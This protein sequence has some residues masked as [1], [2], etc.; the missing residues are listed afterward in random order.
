MSPFLVLEARIHQLQ[1][2]DFLLDVQ[3]AKVQFVKAPSLEK[4]T[5]SVKGSKSIP[6][7]VNAIHKSRQMVH[8]GTHPSRWMKKITE[9]KNNKLKIQQDL[10]QKIQ[11]IQK[12]PTAPS[13]S[14]NGKRSL[15]Q[16]GTSHKTITSTG[17]KKASLNNKSKGQLSLADGI[18]AAVS[19]THTSTVTT[20]A[21]GIAAQ[22]HKASKGKHKHSKKHVSTEEHVSGAEGRAKELLEAE[23][24]QGR[25]SQQAQQWASSSNTQQLQE[26]SEGNVNGDIHLKIRSYLE[27]CVF[28][29]ETER[30]HHFLLSQHRVRRYR[31]HLKTDV[32]N[33][34]MRVWAKKVSLPLDI[35]SFS[36]YSVNIT[37]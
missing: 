30:A 3:H 20:S 6:H 29:G 27:A 17:K 35:L 8:K 7:E 31:K 32:Y 25:H 21:A 33:I 1:S 12:N 15:M 24:L 22:L 18:R 28:A 14:K 26:N 2:S 4:G 36:R 9:E 5:S 23:E 34:M 10:Q 11:N 13:T 16:P 37:S 19:S